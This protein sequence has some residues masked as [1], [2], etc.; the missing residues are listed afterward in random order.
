MMEGKMP[1]DWRGSIIVLIFKQE[2]NA[3]KCSNY[4]GIKLISHTMK[5]YERLVDSKLREMVT[6]SQKQWCSMPERSTTDAYHEKRKP[7]YLAFQDLEKAYDRL[8]RAVL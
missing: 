7:C 2:G 6:I 4:C 3:S 1:D 8:P 5:V